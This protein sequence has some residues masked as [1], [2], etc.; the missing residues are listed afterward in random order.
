MELQHVYPS[1][2]LHRRR[3]ERFL[4]DNGLRYD[5]V[6]HYAMLVDEATGEI[7][8]GGGLWHGIIKCVAVAGSHKGEAFANTIV[9]HLIAFANAE[10]YQ[11]VKLYTS[12][13][14]LRLFES[15]SFRLLA[16]APKAVLMETGIGG[17]E[18]YCKGLKNKVEVTS[19]EQH[20]GGGDAIPSSCMSRS[21][22]IVMNANPFTLGHRRLVE[23]SSELV[24]RLYVVVVR[25]DCSMFSY[26]ERKAMV[27]QGVKDIGNVTVVDGSDYTVSM[28]TF[29]TYFLK[30]ISDASDTQMRLDLDLFRRHIAPSL[31]A[32][33]RFV[34]SEPTDALTRRYNE[35][36]HQLLPDVREMSRLEI[37]GMPVSAS[38]VRRAIE[39]NCLW[40][41]A[42]LVPP[43]TI[44]Y[45]IG[46]L[47]AH[48]LQVELD[49][50]PKPGLV[51]L[52][53]NGAHR[54]MDHALMQR[55]IRTLQ[56][57]FT[58]LA[59]LGIEKAQPEHNDIVNIGIEAEQAMLGATG[60]VNTHKGALF[61]LGLA[62]V[63]AAMTE[64]GGDSPPTGQLVAQMLSDIARRFPDT[65]GTHGSE[66]KA[67][68]GAMSGTKA[69]SGAG[70]PLSQLKGALDNAREGYG[71]LFGEWLPFY[72]NRVVSG[73]SFAL[74]K[75]LLRIMCDLDDTNIVY[76]TS[77]ATMQHVKARARQ[78]LDRYPGVG[79]EAAFVADM[80]AMNSEF[81]AQNI[82]PGGSADMLSLV[83]FL[84]GVVRKR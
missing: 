72:D 60:G 19:E 31:N 9:S 11:C 41:A 71:Q 49:T 15:L 47:A 32:T 83:V 68:A 3:I 61:S 67:K 24:E 57:Y 2:P 65:H 28:A 17:M 74:H 25:E 14:N 54:D 48:A 13:A 30:Q 80:E 63:V 10:G 70:R 12:P 21:G 37:D 26:N 66:A 73:D 40:K 27:C 23:Q 77:V 64:R 34:G 16:E 29:P 59:Q 58:R 46:H 45:I 78:L 36:M 82:S 39:D 33:V 50:T 84:Y 8:A 35:L 69:M 42:R 4:E 43:T 62:T 53:D 22:V 52:C 79:A 81:K 38:R 6:D 5:D 18:E 75:T 44:P 1:I 76:R 56:P 7:V 20:A 51:D 55:S